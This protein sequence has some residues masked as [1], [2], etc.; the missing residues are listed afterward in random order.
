[1]EQLELG[2]SK[3]SPV[4]SR[5]KSRIL[6]LKKTTSVSERLQNV[7]FRCSCVLVPGI[8]LNRVGYYTIPSMGDLADMVDENGQ[9]VVEN[10]SVG[11][12][13]NVSHDIRCLQVRAASPPMMNLLL[14]TSSYSVLM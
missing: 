13:G 8:V 9:C 3:L 7:C 6:V 14:N 10:F 11:R 1:M 4:Q 12:K 2:L 5:R